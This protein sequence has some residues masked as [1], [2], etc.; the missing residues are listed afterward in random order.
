MDRA[1]LVLATLATSAGAPWEP[2]Q[3]QKIFFLL[4]KKLGPAIGGPHWAFTPYDYGPF[5]AAV[6]NSIERLATTG[7][8]TV[9]RPRSGMRT[10]ALTPEGQARGDRALSSMSPPIREYLLQLSRWVRALSFQQ[11]V[12]AVYREFPEMKQNSIFRE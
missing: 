5:D 4:D 3:V 2:V 8:A 6:Y 10:F 1:D 7:L 12:S 9:H 11:L